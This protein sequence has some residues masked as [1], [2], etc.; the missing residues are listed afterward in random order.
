MASFELEEPY[1][2]SEGWRVLASPS[3]CHLPVP[4]VADRKTVGSEIAHERQAADPTPRIPS[5][6]DNEPVRTRELVFE[7]GVDFVREVDA[8]LAWEEADFQVVRSRLA[9]RRW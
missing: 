4:A 6:I 7:N 2:R 3:L 5:K 1:Q 9:A 8:D